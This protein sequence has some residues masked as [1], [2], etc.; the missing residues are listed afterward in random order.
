MCAISKFIYACNTSTTLSS[1]TFNFRVIHENHSVLEH[2]IP[3]W[4]A[5]YFND[6]IINIIYNMQKLHEPREV[7][8]R[9]LPERLAVYFNRGPTMP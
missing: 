4:F 3:D 7:S 2:F 5:S 1:K 8:N 6:V 9:A